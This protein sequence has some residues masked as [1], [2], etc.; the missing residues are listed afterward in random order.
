MNLK[1][2]KGI[3]MITLSIAVIILVIITSVLVYNAKDS[4][5]VKTL[6]NLYNDIE[7]LNNKVSAYYL[8]HG[9]IPKSAKYENLFLSTAESNQV[10]P[11]N[12]D[13]FYVI[14]LKA[15]EGVSLNYGRDFNSVSSTDSTVVALNDIYIINDV[16]HQI[17]YPRGIEVEGKT[18]YTEPDEWTSVNL[19][20]IPI[21]NAEQLAKIGSNETIKINQTGN[22]YKFTMDSIYILQN[23]IDLGEFLHRNDN[24]AT[25]DVSWTPIGTNSNQF[26]GTFYGNGNI[27]NNFYINSNNDYLGLFGCVG[28]NGS[29]KDI[30]VR[31]SIITTGSYIG[32]V[33]GLLA[34]NGEI[35]DCI[36]NVIIEQNYSKT[37]GCYVGGI[38]GSGAGKISNCKNNAKITS[39]STSNRNEVGGIAGSLNTGGSIEKCYNT[40]EINGI[41]NHTYADV[42]GICGLSASSISMSYNSGK[43]YGDSTNSPLEGGIV[44]VANGTSCI[45]KN[46]YNNGTV[47][48]NKSGAWLCGI[49]GDFFNGG[50]CENCFSIGNN[51]LS[52]TDIKGK[53]IGTIAGTTSGTIKNCYGLDS[54][55][56]SISLNDSAG[57]VQNSGLKTSEEMKLQTFVD[58]LNSNQGTDLP[59]VMD[60]IGENEGFPILN[61]QKD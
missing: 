8:E 52:N 53:A 22:E 25:N 60:T 20:V 27:I 11:N 55:Y 45:I 35:S 14:N 32:G 3:N 56:N 36:N 47:S 4:V 39:T 33:V 23:D 16:S 59:W 29:V 48:S 15:L 61:W 58:L 26:T 44:G 41:S 6:K 21:Y 9:D 24:D 49:G 10:N 38:M 28:N 31:G 50:S 57:S 2:Q 37:T 34:S 18:Y 43:I 17:Y 42:G 1:N 19:S 54:N 12:G 5:K 51:I 46:C 7:Q 13:D 30:N 40:G